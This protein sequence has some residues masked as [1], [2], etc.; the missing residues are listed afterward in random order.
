MLKILYVDWFLKILM[1]ISLSNSR[2]IILVKHFISSPELQWKEIIVEMMRLPP[3]LLKQHLTE[4]IQRKMT[5]LYLV[6][7]ALELKDYSLMQNIRLL[8]HTEKIRLK[9]MMKVKLIIQK[10]LELEVPLVQHLVVASE[11]F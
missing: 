7:S 1:Q 8:I 5:K 9:P 11:R 10:I 6:V 4:E 2:P 3:L